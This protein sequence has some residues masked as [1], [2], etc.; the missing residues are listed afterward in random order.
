MKIQVTQDHLDQH[1]VTGY[2]DTALALAI[3]EALG[4]VRV[5]AHQSVRI[6]IEGFG[7]LDPRQTPALKAFVE[8]M[9]ETPE[10]LRPISM[11]M[12]VLDPVAAALG[13]H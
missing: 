6:Y 9:F 10:A 12:K 7:Q 5:V 1:N 2:D 8:M 11:E 3:S 13:I 4:G